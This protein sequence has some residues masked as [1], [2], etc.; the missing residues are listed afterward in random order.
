MTRSLRR[1][2]IFID[3][4]VSTL[5]ITKKLLVAGNTCEKECR[6]DGYAFFL[7]KAIVPIVDDVYRRFQLNAVNDYSQS[8]HSFLLS[9]LDQMGKSSD[10]ND[11][12]QVF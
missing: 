6:Q 2:F 8:G 9:T 12:N 5:H 3:L 11:L 10:K 4:S 7:L 1:V